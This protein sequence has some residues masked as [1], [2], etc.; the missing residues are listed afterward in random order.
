MTPDLNQFRELSQ[1][2]QFS[3]LRLK[4]KDPSVFEGKGWQHH[5]ETRRTFEEIN[6]QEGQNAGVACGPASGVMV[7]DKDH[8]NPN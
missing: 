1:R 4:G 2:R 6:F 3:L 8:A 7:L 5:C